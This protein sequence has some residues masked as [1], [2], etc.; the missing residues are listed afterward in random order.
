MTSTAGLDF[1]I[2]KRD[3]GRRSVSS[4]ELREEDAFLRGFAGRRE[5][6]VPANARSRPGSTTP[7]RCPPG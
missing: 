3:I 7:S 4:I 5:K 1:Q 2:L 6:R